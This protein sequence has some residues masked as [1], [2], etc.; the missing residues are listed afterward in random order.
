MATPSPPENALTPEQFVETSLALVRSALDDDS[1]LPELWRALGDLTPADALAVLEQL[2]A[3]RLPRG[4]RREQ[5]ARARALE[6][7]TALISERAGRTS[8]DEL[9]RFAAD[10]AA[11]DSQSPLATGY[12]FHARGLSAPD[13]ALHRL[14]DKLCPVPFLQLDVLE[15]SAHLCCASWLRRSVGDLST[16]SYDE[17]WHSAA[18]T[19]IRRSI[20]DGSYRYCNKS[21]CP[22][23]TGG[24]LTPRD[25]LSRDPWWAEVLAKGTGEIDRLPRR[26]NLAYDRHCNLSCPSCRSGLITSDEVTRTRLDEITQRNVLPLLAAAHELHVTGSGDPFASKTFRRLLHWID[27]ERCPE[28]KLVLMTNGMLLTRSEWTKF[29]NLAGR[30]KLVKISV[31]GAT[32]ETHEALRRGSRWEVLEPNLVFVGELLRTGAIENYELVFV[33]QRQNYREMG[34]FVDLALRVGA[35]QVHFERMTNWGTFSEL[36]YLDRAVWNPRHPEHAAFRDAMT[37]PR[38]LDPM[39]WIGSLREF[40]PGGGVA[41][42]VQLSRDT[43]PVAAVA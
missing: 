3:G 15:R 31:D 25:E 18:A 21:A 19:E 29:P 4:A 35:N 10:C 30:V 33:V 36:E 16:E 5:P 20:L 40:L 28:L 9:V 13:D 42:P 7:V 32:A 12:Y 22:V 34:A 2:D 6:L 39:V 17:V 8:V 38:L 26:L 37:D 41:R 23:L 27:G 24:L 43:A 1:D 11:R 14:D